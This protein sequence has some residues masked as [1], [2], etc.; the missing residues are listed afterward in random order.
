MTSGIA[1]GES[2]QDTASLWWATSG[3]PDAPVVI[4]GEAWGSEEKARHGRPFVGQSG[5]EL[6]RILADGGLRRDDILCVNIFNGQPEGNDL[7]SLFEPGP[8]TLAGLRPGPEILSGLERLNRQLDAHPRSLIIAAGNYPLW[9]LTNAG[10]SSIDKGKRYPTGIT[11]L[12]GSQEFR[13]RHSVSDRT[14]GSTPVLPIIHPAAILRQ[15]HLR[16]LTVHDLRT[17]VPLVLGGPGWTRPVPYRFD[18]T[19]TFAR[20]VGQLSTWLHSRQE[21]WI[22]ADIETKGNTLI[23]CIGFADSADYAISVPFVR[24]TDDRRIVSYWSRSE[25]ITI[26]KLLDA[27]YRAPHIRWIGQN[28]LYDYQYIHQEWNTVPKIAHDTLIAQNLLFPG[29]PKDLGHLSSLYCAHHRYWKDDSREWS[30]TGTLEQHLLYNCEDAART[31]EIA[32]RQREALKALGLDRFWPF[33][34]FKFNLAWRMMRRGVR[35]D[36]KATARVGAQI[37]ERKLEVDRQLMHT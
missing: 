32:A 9:A 28:F 27:L 21:L 6:D 19:P 2:L 10:G 26:L 11:S 25:E 20:V 17:R 18:A 31:W 35:R 16:P 3:P 4:V 7:G 24:L 15:W 30:K 34:L 8:A 23:T 33:E 29:T 36:P 22:S 1:K 14:T 5:Q 13:V 37:I 12:R